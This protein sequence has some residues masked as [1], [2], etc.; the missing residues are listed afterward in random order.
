MTEPISTSFSTNQELRLSD[1][2][3]KKLREESLFESEEE[4]QKRIDVLEKLQGIIKDWVK[5]VGLKKVN[6]FGSRL[7]NFCKG[8][9]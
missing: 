6:F 5:S 8:D 4:S 2:L 1:E 7:V 9:N 3:E